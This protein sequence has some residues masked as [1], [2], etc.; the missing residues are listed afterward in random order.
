MYK[1][2][3]IALILAVLQWVSPAFA[4]RTEPKLKLKTQF[5]GTYSWEVEDA[6]FGGLSGLEM[7]RSGTWFAAVADTGAFVTGRI[8][9]RGNNQRISGVEQVAFNTMQNVG[10]GKMPRYFNDSEGL[11]MY[12]DGRMFVSFEGEHRVWSY[13]GPLSGATALP[14]HPDF[15]KMQKNSSLEA[16]ALGP[17]GALYTIPERSGAKTR[18]FPVYRYFKG[19]W[20]QKYSIPRSGDFLIVGADFGPDGKFYILERSFGLFG[21]GTRVRR[22]DQT[23]DGFGN[24]DVILQTDMS[25][26]DNLEGINVWRDSAGFIRITMISDDNFNFVQ[27]T[28]FVEYR[29]LR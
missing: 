12:P 26:H 23:V 20:S 22:F 25:V 4:D 7:N 29:V 21:F 27:E 5:L 13:P 18:P 8:I 17:D 9:R 11:A 24:E 15:E 2:Y 14:R 28:E 10:G 19:V 3:F 6:R 1:S 16:L